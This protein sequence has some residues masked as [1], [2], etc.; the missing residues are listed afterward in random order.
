[1]EVDELTYFHILFEA[2]DISVTT[3]T[4]SSN[5]MIISSHYSWTPLDYYVTGRAIAHSNCSWRLLYS[6]SSID[7]DM[8]EVFCQ[9]CDAPG[10]TECR[11]T[12]H[13]QTSVAIASPTKAYSHL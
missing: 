1:M 6:N 10:G 4:L 8:F 9:G 11:A 2:K 5:Q 3:T 13:M 7:D 12:S